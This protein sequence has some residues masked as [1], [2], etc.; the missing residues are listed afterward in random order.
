[1]VLVKLLQNFLIGII[2]M[3]FEVY[4]N[5]TCSKNTAFINKD[6]I[7][8]KTSIIKK[9]MEDSYNKGFNH[10]KEIVDSFAKKTNSAISDKD[11]F[12]M[13]PWNK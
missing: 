13:F 6:V 9:L 7:E 4:W 3:E 5:K 12:N 8:I 11:I 1:M 2:K 10:H